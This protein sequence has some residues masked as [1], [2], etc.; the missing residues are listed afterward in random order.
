MNWQWNRKH[1]RCTTACVHLN[2]YAQCGLAP[3]T[4]FRPKGYTILRDRALARRQSVP[5]SW[6]P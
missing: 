3:A 1:P 2:N 4:W 5:P 6:I